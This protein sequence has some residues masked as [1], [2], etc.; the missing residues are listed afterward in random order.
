MPYIPQENRKK[1][2]EKIIP[3]FREAA[4][5]HHRGDVGDVNYCISQLIWRLFQEN[6]TYRRACELMGTLECA[7]A[8]FY[9]R[10]VAPY[11]DKK[12]EANGDL[13]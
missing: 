4:N 12:I 2:D 13:L 1:L 7:K 3:L 11:E 10:V 5:S 8:E 9:R 6:P